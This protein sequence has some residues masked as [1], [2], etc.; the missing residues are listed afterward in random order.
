MYYSVEV[1]SN[2]S[3]ASIIDVVQLLAPLAQVRQVTQ[4]VHWE[5]VG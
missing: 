2:H 1:R 5:C 4:P 3:E